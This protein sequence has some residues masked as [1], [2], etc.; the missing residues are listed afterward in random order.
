MI[1]IEIRLYL[2]FV[3][4]ILFAYSPI[5]IAEQPVSGTF[6]GN[7][8]E[9]KLSYAVA[10]PGE[11]FSGEETVMVVLTEK[12]PG[13][14]DKPD[15]DAMFGKL[16]SALILTFQRSGDLI[17]CE[18]AHTAH[19][20]MPFSS[21]GNMKVSDFSIDRDKLKAKVNTGGQ[22]ETYG[23]TWEVELSIDTVIRK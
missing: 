6:K 18:V 15:F 21:I 9:A 12:D 16:G 4:A 8:K 5:L 23:Q 17:G 2:L 3:I 10:R 22:V 19:E 7:G 13:D 1:N 20:K 14:N 11:P